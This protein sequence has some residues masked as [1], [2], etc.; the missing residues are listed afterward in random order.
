MAG[1]GRPRKPASLKV[2]EGEK[3]KSRIYPE[4]DACKATFTDVPADL[5]EH[6]R[7]MWLDLAPK[8]GRL[9]ITSELDYYAFEAMC[10]AYDAWRN[11]PTDMKLL[12]RLQ[13]LLGEHGCTPSSR[14]KVTGYTDKAAAD[15]M[16]RLL[17]GG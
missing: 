5:G 13:S 8:L 15:P 9:G 6:G 12:T 11:D 1:P 10:R 17:A 3:D 16:A 14:S 2:L 7:S 4:P